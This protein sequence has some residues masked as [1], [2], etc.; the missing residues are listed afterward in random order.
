MRNAADGS[1]TEIACAG[2]FA[3]V[4]LAPNS[5]FL[6]QTIARDAQGAV[7]TNS[8]LET[9]LPGVWAA[10]AV[11]GGYT[12]LLADAVKEAE[13]AAAGAARRVKGG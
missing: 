13:A 8:A 1:H 5:G 10:G 9:A 6:P 11:R 4:G 3:Y 12:G 7:V 2:F